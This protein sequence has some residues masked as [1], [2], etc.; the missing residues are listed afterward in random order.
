MQQTAGRWTGALTLLHESVPA[1]PV[2]RA[3]LMWGANATVI[4]RSPT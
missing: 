4:L 3:R 1:H 2:E